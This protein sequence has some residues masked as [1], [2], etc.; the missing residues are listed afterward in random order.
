MNDFCIILDLFLRI[1]LLRFLCRTY[2]QTSIPTTVRTRP[3]VTSIS[4]LTSRLPISNPCI[5]NSYLASQSHI[6]S[7][8]LRRIFSFDLQP[9][10]G[11]KEL[12]LTADSSLLSNQDPCQQ[13]VDVSDDDCGGENPSPRRIILQHPGTNEMLRTIFDPDECDL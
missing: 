8:S 2:C 1:F 4:I 12:L 11:S 5:L 6:L 3:A 7:I 13:N 10:S 9:P